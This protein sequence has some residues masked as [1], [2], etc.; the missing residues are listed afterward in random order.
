MKN[1]QT[2]NWFDAAWAEASLSNL[3]FIANQL[4]NVIENIQPIAA[5]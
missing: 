1:K 2:G 3:A 4:R 5:L